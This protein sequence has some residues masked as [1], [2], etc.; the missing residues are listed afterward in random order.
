MLGRLDDQMD[1]RDY[2]SAEAKDEDESGAA[3][4]AAAT[5][6]VGAAA[7]EGCGR[8]ALSAVVSS[9]VKCWSLAFLD[10]A[11]SG[12]APSML[13]VA[14]MYLADRGYGRI[15]PDRAEGVRWLMRCV[16]LDEGEARE[17][18]RRH[19]PEELS[20]WLDERRRRGEHDKLREE[21]QNG[22]ERQQVDCAPS[23]RRRRA[24]Q[25]QQQDGG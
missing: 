24:A 14:Q 19:C 6:E 22:R 20:R 3:A 11:R 21:E 9:L 4:V 1:R 16:E 13:L 25:R 10:L 23:E 18:A 2:G 17:M 7:G 15:R 12:D 5:S 8:V